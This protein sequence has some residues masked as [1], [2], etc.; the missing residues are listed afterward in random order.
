MKNG[1]QATPM[2]A[3]TSLMSGGGWKGLDTFSEEA[4]AQNKK[5]AQQRYQRALE[6]SQAFTDT[7]GAVA[8]GILRDMTMGQPTFPVDTL[9]LANA[10]GFGVYREGQNSLVRWIEKQIEIAEQGPPK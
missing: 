4:Q 9:G 6:V 2:D 5:Q 1:T 10:I 8:L 3:L 7:K